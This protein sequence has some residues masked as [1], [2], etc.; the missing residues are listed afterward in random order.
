MFTVKWHRKFILNSQT[1]STEIVLVMLSAW[2]HNFGGLILPQ[3]KAEK[4]RKSSPVEFCIFMSTTGRE[5]GKI[6][7][8]LS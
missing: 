1:N 3:T 5:R 4:T 7:L 6:L 2:T 8:M